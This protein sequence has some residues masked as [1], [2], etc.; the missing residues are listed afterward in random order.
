LI[1]IFDYPNDY[2]INIIGSRAGE[3]KHETLLSSEEMIQAQNLDSYYMFSDE[4]INLNYSKYINQGIKID[5]EIKSFNSS[6][7]K[8]LNLNEVIN[9]L[10]KQ[11]FI[12]NKIKK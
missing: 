7:T 1:K 10:E 5:H 9:L 3:K 11:N 8:I 4:S 2:P 6:N 12:L